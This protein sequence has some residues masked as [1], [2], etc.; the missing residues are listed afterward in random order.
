[1]QHMED[2]LDVRYHY[3][4]ENRIL[5]WYKLHEIEEK[6][7]LKKINMYLADGTTEAKQAICNLVEQDGFIEIYKTRNEMSYIINAVNIYY[8]ELDTNEPSTILD[9]ADSID[10]L[11]SLTNRVRFSIW[12]LE[13][14]EDEISAP[15][16]CELIQNN[17]ISVTMLLYI[18]DATA[19]NKY[20][21]AMKLSDGFQNKKMYKYQLYILLFIVDRCRGDET[22]LCELA[23]LYVRAGYNDLAKNCLKQINQPGSLT[24]S[25]RREYGL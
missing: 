17:H 14:T 5:E 2:K 7:Y 12:E 8:R 6:Q 10:V 1:M 23:Q 19:I 15:L 3:N 25:V 24:E 22:A 9:I 20:L 13:Y 16:L 11:I 21:V 4:S 18:L